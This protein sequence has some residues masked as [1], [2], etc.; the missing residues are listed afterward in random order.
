MF[1]E[2][3]H[4]SIEVVDRSWQADEI[5]VQSIIKGCYSFIHSSTSEIKPF[6]E[7]I[8]NRKGPI[9]VGVKELKHFVKQRLKELI[10]DAVKMFPSFASSR[11]DPSSFSSSFSKV[12]LM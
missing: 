2:A 5:S 8:F 4:L 1:V 11:I 10:G 3:F 7:V 12:V 9:L 6:R